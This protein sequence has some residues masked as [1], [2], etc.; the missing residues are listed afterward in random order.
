MISSSNTIAYCLFDCKNV[1]HTEICDM[2]HPMELF[3][4]KI[5][6][7]GV[8]YFLIV[9]WSSVLPLVP[10]NKIGFRL[11]LF[12]LCK[13]SL[14]VF[15]LMTYVSNVFSIKNGLKIKNYNERKIKN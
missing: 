4:P 12:N 7:I 2:E 8:V 15:K 3:G 10:L 9:L 6:Y 5:E 11:H 1:F 13:R 14:G